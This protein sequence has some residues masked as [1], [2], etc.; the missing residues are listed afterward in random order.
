MWRKQ[1]S[2]SV[3]SIQK[4]NWGVTTHFSELTKLQFGKEHHTLLCILELFKNIV[5]KLSLKYSW[6]PPILFLDFNNT[7]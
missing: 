3:L 4:E 1:N 7:C 5:H 2:A 6:V